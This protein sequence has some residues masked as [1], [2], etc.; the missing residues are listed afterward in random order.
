VIAARY[1]RAFDPTNSPLSALAIRLAGVVDAVERH[2]RA[3]AWP[4]LFA[5]QDLVD[6]VEPGQRYAGL[7]RCGALGGD[8]LIARHGAADIVEHGLDIFRRGIGRQLG[9]ASARACRAWRSVSSAK[10]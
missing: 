8:V 2:E 6:G 9:Q 7:F 1:Y 4:L 10:R 5:E 3:E